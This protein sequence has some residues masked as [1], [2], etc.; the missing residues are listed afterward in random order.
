MQISKFI[1]FLVLFFFT[2]AFTGMA[3]TSQT[4]AQTTPKPISTSVKTT[5]KSVSMPVHIASKSVAVPVKTAPKSVSTPVKVTPKLAST[6][7]RTTPKPV[8]T[9]VRTTP[10]PVSTAVRTTPR[11]VS[12][13]VYHSAP[14]NAAKIQFENSF[15]DLGTIKE[16]AILE[17]SFEFTNIGA[18]DLVIINAEGS[19][20]CT[21]PT[22]P[23][24][25]IPPGGKGKI[26]VKYTAKNKVGPQKPV[27]TV[28]TNGVP[29]TVK[30]NMDVWVD[31]IPGG[32]KDGN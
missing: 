22:V 32:V 26:L 2:S 16:D 10:K 25:P 5:P 19:C 1:L 13:P 18:T 21:L 15:L 14:S 30:L 24:Y 29:S 23:N 8:S 31:Q 12:T 17:K 3:Q 9:A 11:S 27:V 28:T 6:A 4:N 7:V 20:G